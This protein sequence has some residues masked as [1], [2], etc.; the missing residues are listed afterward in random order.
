[1]FRNL[2]Y[3]ILISLILATP[4]MWSNELYNGL[5]SAKQ[6]W[7]YVAMAFLIG[8]FAVDV[9]VIRRRISIGLN[10]IDISLLIFYIYLLIRTYYTPYTPILYNQKFVNYS[11]LLFFYFI[12][13]NVCQRSFMKNPIF[14]N[15]KEENPI[16]VVVTLILMLTGL[17]EAIWG[18]MQLYGWT[19]SFHSRFKITG[20]FFNPAPYALYLAA[21]FPIALTVLM[22]ELRNERIKKSRDKIIKDQRIRELKNG[23][24]GGIRIG[25]MDQTVNLLLYIKNK[26]SESPSFF[27]LSFHYLIRFIAWLT[28]ISILLVIPATMNRA[29][30]VGVGVSS[31]FIFNQ[32]YHLIGRHTRWLKTGIR[33][34]IIIAGLLVLI[35]T[36]TIGL[37]QVKRG[38]SIGRL[39]IWEVTVRKIA[40][41]PLFGYGVGR[42]E[43]EYN[44]WQAEYF[45]NHP[46]ETEGPRGMAAGNTKYCFNEYLEIASEMGII[47]LALFLI[48]FLFLLILPI[49]DDSSRRYY[50]RST[51]SLFPCNFGHSVIPSSASTDLRFFNSFISLLACAL[52]SYPFYSLS[53]LI[54]FFLL[55]AMVSS[56]VSVIKKYNFSQYC[57]SFRYS[58]RLALGLLLVSVVYFLLNLTKEQ[59][60]NSINMDEGAKLYQFRSYNEAIQCFEEVYPYLKYNG[61][62]LQYYGK[63]L[64]MK[65]DFNK[66]VEML[67]RARCFTA[68]EVLHTTLGDTYKAIKRYTEAEEAYQYASFMVPHKL[69]PG[70]LLAK[71]YVEI[72]QNEKS[73]RTAKELLNKKIK[74]KSTATK[75]ILEAI[76]IL[77]DRMKKSKNELT[78]NEHIKKINNRTDL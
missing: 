32:E 17:I 62:Y 76:K 43:A 57:P 16:I 37:Y 9:V 40:E 27:L 59:Y 7:F 69:Y 10:L 28:V 24:I 15:S 55:S 73:L 50:L 23:K 2:L 1:M 36:I 35:A 42:F 30:W 6:I 18:L 74:V 65:G 29:S 33:K 11:L 61:P 22:R 71:L 21:I 48:I 12:V 66:G 68:D 41:K 39:F 38:S 54:I 20:T 25:Q 52:I 13:K 70:Y 34:I 56:D 53:T 58:I 78:L 31:F 46:V 26:L 77:I 64:S 47:G 19:Q 60:K 5:I 45:K 44:N 72:G 4:F 51:P 49:R 63:A 14:E 3:S 75:E 67:E 8:G